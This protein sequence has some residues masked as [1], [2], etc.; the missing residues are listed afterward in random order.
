MNR[1]KVQAP[2]R[3]TAALLLSAGTGFTA[4]AAGQGS[5]PVQRPNILWLTFEDS[6][7]YEFGCYGN[8]QVHTPVIDSLASVG[9]RYDRAWAAAPQSS[10]ARSSLITGC[11]ALSFGM[12]LHPV[13][14]D[15]P[16]DIFFPSLLRDAGYYCTNNNKTH[17]NTT[18]D[19]NSCWDE[20]GRKASY[21][22]PKRAEG[23]PFF[24]VYNAVTSHMGRV[25]TFHTE[26]RRDY[27]QEGIIQE[28]LVLPGHL[29]DLPEIRSDYAAHLEAI[30]D[31]D[32]WVGIFLKDLSDS[33]LADNTIVFVF[34]DHGGCLP[35]GKGYV[36]ET[37]L[38]VPLVVYFPE[39][40]KHLAPA[41]PGS[42]DSSLVN[43]VDLGPSVL[44]LAGVKTPSSMEG[45]P[46]MGRYASSRD[47]R[48][49]YAFGTNQLHHFMPMRAVRDGRFKYIRSYIP[50][51]QIALRN[52]Y[53]WGMPA[54]M[55]WDRL[56]LSAQAGEAEVKDEL[57]QPFCHH[58][59]EML[60]DL[61]N[62][63][64]EL[65]NLA[66]DPSFAKEL[67]RMRRREI[68]HERKNADLGFFIPSS[69]PDVN[70][71]DRVHKGRYPLRKLLRLISKVGMD[72]V[73]ALPLFQR[74]ILSEDP[75]FRFWGTVGIT[76]LAVSG[77][78]SEIPD[79]FEALLDDQ[80][81][82]VA[83]EAAIA[84]AYLG[85]PGESASFLARGRDEESRKIFF[86]ALECLAL[87]P[88]M[89]DDIMPCIAVL[90][91]AADNLPHV[92]N[93][94][95]GF[96]ARGILVDLGLMDVA[97]IYAPEGYDNGL[98]LNAGRRK[99]APLP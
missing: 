10:P 45:R 12:D 39:K 22:S 55:A 26:G 48:Y 20:C 24:S 99:I 74:S 73:S 14:C 91:E 53:Q 18:T 77:L 50:Y 29:P 21:H 92:E 17:Y 93:E 3:L 60:F 23:Q 64:S 96:M 40:W 52:Y 34:S 75:D 78:I 30:Q 47:K 37:G 49:D 35:R 71:Y 43:F 76:S 61:E 16:E 98:R 65:N 69:R 94:D 95:A 46:F 70:M 31:I 2:S 81:D 83:A 4:L 7:W 51:R 85:K 88:Q 57:L 38:H 15:T 42:V 19:N 84:L 27:A 32:K 41:A 66:G 97:G 33:G 72:D 9:I 6:S 79:G 90:Q 63:P 54:N 80:C 67:K 5:A 11:Y 56:A 58:A 8:A 1:I 87:D 59:G 25:R 89:R 13:A 28:D 86:S 36:Y 68:R 62:D 44:S 82:Y